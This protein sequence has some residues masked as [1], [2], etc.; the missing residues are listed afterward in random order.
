MERDEADPVA[1]LERLGASSVRWLLIGRQALIQYGAPL[2]T[3]DYDL[4]VDPGAANLRRFLALAGGA[5]LESPTLASVQ[6]RP[7]FTLH[8][9]LLK[10]DVFKVRSFRNLDG[11]EIDFASAWRRRT[12]ASAPGDPLRLPLPRL[13]DLRRL[14]RMRDGE[15]DREDLRYIDQL[16]KTK[17]RRTR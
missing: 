6:G 13:D 5:G 14:K 4:W 2:Q 15:K 12:V 17:R 7:Y 3:M 10:V 8:G 16:T 11:E 1:F 9:G